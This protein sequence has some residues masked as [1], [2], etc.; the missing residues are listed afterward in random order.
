[1]YHNIIL[2]HHS[3]VNIYHASKFIEW[4]QIIINCSGNEFINN[5]HWIVNTLR[6]CLIRQIEKGKNQESSNNST[7][8]WHNKFP[9]IRSDIIDYVNWHWEIIVMLI[10]WFILLSPALS[11]CSVTFS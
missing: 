2:S 4:L 7:L 11:L 5:T 3:T 9:A 8:P 10:V 1:M 6:F